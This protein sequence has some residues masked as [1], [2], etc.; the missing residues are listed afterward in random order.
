MTD[1]IDEK[2]IKRFIDF[3]AETVKATKVPYDRVQE[4]I[5]DFLNGLDEED[6]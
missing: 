6:V 4:I 5:K 2:I 1:G 3:T